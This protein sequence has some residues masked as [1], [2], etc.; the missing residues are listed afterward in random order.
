MKI[1]E[2]LKKENN[3]LDL[4]RIFLASFVILGHTIAINGDTPF[5]IDPI[6]FVF[7]ITYSGAIAVKIF[8]FIS[9]LVVTN[10]YLNKNDFVYFII[11]RI[12]RILPALFFLLLITVFIIGPIFTKL[13]INEYFSSQDYLNYLKNNMLFRTEWK[14]P[15][16]FSE[17]FYKDSINGSLWSLHYE[18]FA[19]LYLMIVFLII[20]IKKRILFNLI[21][22]IIIL[23]SLLPI[24]ILFNQ[25]SNN[26]EIYLLPFAFA[27]GSFFAINSKEIRINY[28]TV[29]LS[30]T[31]YI[32]SKN[33]SIEEI[34]LIV[35]F[36]NLIVYISSIK[37][38]LNFKPKHDISYGIYLWG[39]LVQQIV[40]YLLGKLYAGTHFIIALVF[41][42]IIAYISFIFIEKPFINLGR[43]TFNIYNSTIIKL[44]NRLKLS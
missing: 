35:F 12:F 24:R 39:F 11:A 33:T 2:F 44:K 6:L 29:L 30:L 10:S 22:I 27:L 7:K 25:N 23:D 19:Y 21:F 41:S 16:L 20:R 14:L 1:E 28:L 40:Y 26:P 8:F 5:W 13:T 34:F 38:I 36:C 3:N 9:G 42:L 18:M 43:K 31:C 17:N 4:I 32:I 15:G 37:I